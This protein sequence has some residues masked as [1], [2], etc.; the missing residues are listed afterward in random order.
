MKRD[1]WNKEFQV[2]ITVGDSITA[3]GWA[4]CR[5]RGWPEQL[6]RAI[7]EYQRVPVQL[8]NM[9]IGANVLSTKSVR[10]ELSGKPAISERLGGTYWVTR[11]TGPRSCRIC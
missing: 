4:S 9:G 1:W 5:Q 11:P 3:G 8:V 6:A 2:L 10:Y 7:N